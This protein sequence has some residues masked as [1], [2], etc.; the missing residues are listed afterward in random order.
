MVDQLDVTDVTDEL[1]VLADLAADFQMLTTV[2]ADNADLCR[3]VEV[4]CF[5]QAYEKLVDI[6]TLNDIIV[7]RL[8]D[9]SMESS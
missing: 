7:N 8:N 4:K 9:L 6:V 3:S 1:I 5:Y 2:L